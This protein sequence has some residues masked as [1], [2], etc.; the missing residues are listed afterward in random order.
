[1][2]WIGPGRMHM[3]HGH[4]Q[5]VGH[6]HRGTTS[7]VYNQ[8]LATAD[9]SRLQVGSHIQFI[10]AWRPDTDEYDIATIYA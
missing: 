9:L 8:G 1:L 5:M 10:G 6:L 2:P 3:S 4:A 7:A